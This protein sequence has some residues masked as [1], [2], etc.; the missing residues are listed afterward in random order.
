MG[1]NQFG[2]CDWS[3]FLQSAEII[4]LQQ[5]NRGLTFPSP[6]DRSRYRYRIAQNLWKDDRRI[7][8]NRR[9][10]LQE[11]YKPV[12]HSERAQEISVAQQSVANTL[13]RMKTDRL[14]SPKAK[15]LSAKNIGTTMAA[16]LIEWKLGGLTHGEM[17]CM[18][19]KV[20]FST[21]AQT[22]KICNAI[23]IAMATFKSV[24][25]EQTTC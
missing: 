22:R 16:Q 14:M 18:V 21:A 11:N 23:K 5:E 8:S 24:L 15:R 2:A 17:A 4:L 25:L 19:F 3:D 20:E 6:E 9:R 7:E 1:F 12:D 10:I 13:A